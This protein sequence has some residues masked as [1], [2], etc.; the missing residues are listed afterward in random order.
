[1]IVP[2]QKPVRMFKE[3]K[4]L[5][6]MLLSFWKGIVE[7][8]GAR[9]SGKNPVKK[10]SL[11]NGFI[12]RVHRTEPKADMDLENY[13]TKVNIGHLSFCSDNKKQLVKSAASTSYY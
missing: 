11:G 4:L 7:I 5:R 1:M 3:E 12:A 8:F 13:T 10:A 6:K 2:V 9:P